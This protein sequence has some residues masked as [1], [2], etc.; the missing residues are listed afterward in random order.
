M[1]GMQT[2]TDEARINELLTRGVE[3]LMPE[4]LAWQKLRSGEQLRIYLGIDPT[5]SKLHLGHSVPLRKLK[6]FGELGHH[7]IFLV[8][9]FTAMVGDPTGRT[10]AREPLTRE[11]V[12]KN[13]ET[14]KE[15]A[16]KILDFSKVELRYNHEWLEKLSFADLAQ[17]TNH[18]SIQQ[19]LRRDMFRERLKRDED[20]SP[21]EFLYPVMQAYDSVMLDVD[22]ELGGNDQLF[23]MLAGRKLHKAFNKRDKFVLGT[24]L[25]EG[26]D[27]RKMSKTYENCVYLEDSSDEMYG[28]LM[29]LRDDLMQTY[30]EA[31]TDMPMEEVQAIL[32]GHPKE[33]KMR[34]AREIVTM[35][36]STEAATQAEENWTKTFSDGGVPEDML[37]ISVSAGEKVSDK[38]VEAGIVASKSEL[39][40]LQEGG[41]IS[42]VGGDVHANVDSIDK[43]PIVLRIGKHR[44]VR[45]I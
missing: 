42:E 28:K 35:Y 29:T 45:I 17:L 14:Y 2:N 38:L 25:I 1:Q 22:C 39:R 24:R 40:R 15:Q 16:S 41:A 21:N 27:G 3:T 20:L 5:G 8:G 44:F 19:M 13:F 12:E 18:F 7:I 9:S 34:L 23:N 31:A 33:A 11:Q 43:R 4:D 10:T 26:L 6:A 37:E 32:E 30:F 36:H